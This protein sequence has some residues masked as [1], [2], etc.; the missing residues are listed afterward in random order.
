MKAILH[1][2]Y[3]P[4]EGLIYQDVEKPTPKENE[5]LVRVHAA[6]VNRTDSANLRAQPF[7]IRFM[8]GLL[9]PNN[10]ATGTDFAGEVVAIGKHV[11]EFAPGE[12][13]FGFDD[14]GLS[15]HAEYLTIPIDKG[16]DLIPADISYAEAAAS[17]EGAHYARNFLNKVDLKAD[18]RVLINGATGAI[19]SAMLQLV[20]ARGVYVTAVCN[21][22]NL[23][24]IQSL[25]ADRVI[26]YQKEDFT[27]DKERYHFVF[28]AVGK[29]TFRLC[30]PLLLPG[31]VYISSELGWMAQ[32]LF[33][34][35]TTPLLGGK[36]V[37][38]PIPS[39]IKAS[40]KRVKALM[41]QGKFKAVI[42]RGYSLET[43]VEAFHYVES[44]QK[45]GNVVVSL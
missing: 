32:N 14:N 9:K 33:Y 1:A 31:G 6:T 2:R 3:G 19:G 15:S 4:P 35:L 38:F 41:E 25:G 27:L 22:K 23:E 8:T 10:L 12:R 36:K 34:A 39:N 18:S 17:I 40:I 45:T 44:G 13:V 37:I 20:K 24:L 30:K 11:K 28:D 7:V 16:V 5:I 21:T 29:S 43:I 42:D 26:D